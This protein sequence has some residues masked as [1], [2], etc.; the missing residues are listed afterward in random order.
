MLGVLGVDTRPI[1]AGAGILGLAGGLGA[2]SL[3]TDV[4]SGFFILFENQYLVGDYIKIGDAFGRVEVVSIR[5]KQIRDEQG[6]LHIIPNG[7]VK[8]VVNYSKGYGYAEV[9]LKLPAS[10][11]LGDVYRAMSEAGRRVWLARREVLADTVIKGLVDLT[12][13][14]ITV[15]AV[16]RVQPGPHLAMQNEYRRL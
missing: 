9:D 10:S 3:V 5:C 6:R 12:P 13:N 14:E 7:Q 15:R 11:D 8:G 16:T 4:V 1:L 2:Q